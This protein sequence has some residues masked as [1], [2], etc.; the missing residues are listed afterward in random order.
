[1]KLYFSPSEQTQELCSENTKQG[2]SE[3][4]VRYGRSSNNVISF[5]II[6][7]FTRKKKE[8]DSQPGP[9][10]VWSLHVLPVSAWVFSRY[11]G[12]FPHPKDAHLR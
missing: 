9:L 12:F 10:S 2:Q 7:T 1:M 4:S 11:S 6:I 5:N 3:N 8:N